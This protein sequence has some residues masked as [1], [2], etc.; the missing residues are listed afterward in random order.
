MQFHLEQK[1]NNIDIARLQRE[2]EEI[3]KERELEAKTMA[4]LVDGLKRA[5]KGVADSGK[6]DKLMEYLA[7][8]LRTLREANRNQS[9][10]FESLTQK[11]AD[12]QA[13]RQD[14]TISL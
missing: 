11:L 12:A 2:W 10:Y 6:L 7:E 13:P 14:E 3:R 5:I 8:Q 9:E 1:R 4:K